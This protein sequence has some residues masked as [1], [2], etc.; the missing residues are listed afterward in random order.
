MYHI[1]YQ[2]GL[3][4]RDDLLRQ[5]AGERLAKQ[6][7]VTPK[8]SRRTLLRPGRRARYAPAEPQRS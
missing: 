5:A 4:R 1:P 6:V 2:L 3:E 8:R 7:A